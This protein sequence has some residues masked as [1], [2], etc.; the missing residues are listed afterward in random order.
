MPIYAVHP[1]AGRPI[2][3]G[4]SRNIKERFSTIQT[5]SPVPLVL[6]ATFDGDIIIERQMHALLASARSHG[7]WFNVCMDAVHDAYRVAISDAPLSVSAESINPAFDRI[8]LRVGRIIDFAQACGTS[9]SQACAWRRRGIP[10]AR[11]ND[12]AAITGA[13]IDDIKAATR[14][15][16]DQPLRPRVAIQGSSA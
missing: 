16:P 13:S 6:A 7:E 1:V 11:W 8:V 4:F 10:A 3:V 9:E 14:G 12:V 2:K 15:A 5:G